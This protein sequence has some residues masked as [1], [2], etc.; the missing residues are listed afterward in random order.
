MDETSATHYRPTS[1]F[2]EDASD[3]PIEWIMGT[4][5]LPVRHLQTTS[6]PPQPRP[7]EGPHLKIPPRSLFETLSC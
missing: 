5:I 6:K 4:P 7:L 3:S 2:K 1:S